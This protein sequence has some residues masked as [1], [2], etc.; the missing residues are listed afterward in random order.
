MARGHWVV[1]YEKGQSRPMTKKD[2]KGYLDILDDA[3]YMTKIS[4]RWSRGKIIRKKGK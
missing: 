3:L 2:A 4:G 1:V